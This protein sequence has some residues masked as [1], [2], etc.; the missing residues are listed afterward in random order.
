MARLAD[1]AEECRKRYRRLKEAGDQVT[2]A[3]KV[4]ARASYE[5]ALEQLSRFLADSRRSHGRTTLTRAAP[6]GQFSRSQIG[7]DAL[8]DAGDV[9]QGGADGSTR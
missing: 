6:A 2:E 9:P 7:S 3:E 1:W 8:R 5:A 4:E